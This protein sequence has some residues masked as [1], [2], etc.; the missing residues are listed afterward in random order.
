MLHVY[1]PSIFIDGIHLH[2]KYPKYLNTVYFILVLI[3]DTR[4]FFVQVS[5]PT[6]TVAS[7]VFYIYIY[8]Y[9]CIYLS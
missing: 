9:I 6:T 4:K 1:T 8:I 5:V 7:G 3:V 2:S